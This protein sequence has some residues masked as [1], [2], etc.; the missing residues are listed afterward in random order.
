MAGCCSQPCLPDLIS[1]ALTTLDNLSPQCA[2]L[3]LGDLHTFSAVLTFGRQLR[4]VGGSGHF[5]LAWRLFPRYGNGAAWGSALTRPG[6]DEV[7]LTWEPDPKS[8]SESRA[9]PV[10]AAQPDP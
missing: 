8:G 2:D 1:S 5:F 10:G 3:R 4:Y 6:A 9:S 7:S